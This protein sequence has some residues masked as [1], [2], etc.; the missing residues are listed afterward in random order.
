MKDEGV[1]LIVVTDRG[2]PVGVIT[3][4]HI[5]TRLAPEQVAYR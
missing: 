3:D 2:K 4:Y 5:L 1:R